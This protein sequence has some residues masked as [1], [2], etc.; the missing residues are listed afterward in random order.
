MIMIDQS[1]RLS[2]PLRWGR[3]EKT[4]IAVL[5]SC[6]VLGVAGL[7]ALALR[8]GGPVR[9]DC[10]SPALSVALKSMPA[11]R[12]RGW[13][14]PRA[15]IAASP[16]NCAWRAGAPGSPSAAAEMLAAV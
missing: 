13:S 3:R 9:K 5:L 16:R 10:V 12:T 11:G 14:A 2:E 15:P 1:K 6:V 4:V 8:S 7:G